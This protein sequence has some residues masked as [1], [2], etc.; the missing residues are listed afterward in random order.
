MI[1]KLL[2]SEKLGKIAARE[3]LIELMGGFLLTKS[4]SVLN[5]SS[6]HVVSLKAHQIRFLTFT[7]L[8]AIKM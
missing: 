2:S 4:R 3:M 7:M 8:K 1:R 5:H 6:V